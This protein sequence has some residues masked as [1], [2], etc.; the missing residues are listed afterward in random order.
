MPSETTK[1]LDNLIVYRQFD[2]VTIQVDILGII[3]LKVFILIQQL[4]DI[5]D[6]IITR[7]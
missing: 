2:G 1:G 3:Q 6:I 5:I 7:F 4:D